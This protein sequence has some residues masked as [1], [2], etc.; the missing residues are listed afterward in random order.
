MIFRVL[1]FPFQSL[2]GVL[3]DLR[4]FDNIEERILAPVGARFGSG[5]N[6]LLRLGNSV[7][8]VS[9]LIGG[10]YKRWCSLTPQ[11]QL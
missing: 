11:I 4:G 3:F 10:S 2:W 8:S 1:S 7:L 6:S 9:W 5:R